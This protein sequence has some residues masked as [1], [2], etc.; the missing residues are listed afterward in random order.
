MV[1]YFYSTLYTRIAPP[2]EYSRSLWAGSLVRMFACPWK[3]GG[4]DALAL[5]S[6]WNGQ[7]MACTVA[8]W[9]AMDLMGDY[10]YGPF[11]HQKVADPLC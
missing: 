10:P 11:V 1:K 7:G 4:A 9:E 2:C 3:E 8:D 5:H 6:M